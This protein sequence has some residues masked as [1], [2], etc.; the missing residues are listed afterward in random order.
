MNTRPAFIQPKPQAPGSALEHL[1]GLP[2]KGPRGSVRPSAR[3]KLRALSLILVHLLALVHIAHWK[4][5]GE[6]L[7]P[8][9]PSE[10]MQTFELGYVNAGFLL[11][12]ISIAVTMVVGRF[13]CGWACHVVAYQDLCAW[14]LKRLGLAPRPVRSRVL[15]WIPLLTAGYMFLWPSLE[16]ALRG[17]T[18]PKLQAHLMTDDLWATFPGPWITALTFLVDGALIVWLLGAKGFCTYG[19]PYGALF[20]LAGRRAP[21]GIRVTSACE[22]C[23]HCTATCTSNVQV[24]QEVARFGQVVDPGCMRC[25]DCVSVCPKEALYLGRGP[26][27]KAG[28]VFAAPATAQ[29]RSDFSW[30]EEAALA[31]C[32]LAS[33]YAWRGL[34]QK[35]PLLLAIG[36]AVI[37]A[38]VGVALVRML[39]R[40]DFQFQ[41][42][43]LKQ[44]SK[45][46]ARGYQALVLALGL[47]VGTAHSG[48]VQYK[49][50]EG[51]RY[52]VKAGALP[53][54]IERTTAIH[55]S[56]EALERARSLGWLP[57]AKLE[58]QLGS[59]RA[60]LGELAAAR[61]HLERAIEI[62]PSMRVPRVVLAD[63]HKR[64]GNDAQAVAI[65]EELLVLDPSNEPALRR[66]GRAPRPPAKTEH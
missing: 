6:S 46:T 23:G 30:P 21:I 35:V 8:M 40:A 24:A 51:E 66:L 55:R 47:F 37:C 25:M 16:R 58:H 42:W 53:A 65:L 62:D 10:A 29:A 43:K 44:N 20:S 13:F 11:L 17:G 63:V 14:I 48:A 32:F 26:R 52:L 56:L 45:L 27:A 64:M 5:S 7:T 61:A 2:G 36:L 57:V 54:G 34:Y 59:I 60:D 9:E 12:V 50:R 1:P 3:S 41:H 19:C 31:A 38:V 15:L 49:A 18:F 28:K 39:R 22:G 33:L 4:R